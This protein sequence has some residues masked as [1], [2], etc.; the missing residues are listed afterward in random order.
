MVYILTV[1]NTTS[2]YDITYWCVLCTRNKIKQYS[3]T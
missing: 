3:H 1:V 2:D